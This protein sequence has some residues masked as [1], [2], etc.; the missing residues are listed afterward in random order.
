[1][2]NTLHGVSYLL[3]LSSTLYTPSSASPSQRLPQ[4]IDRA[5]FSRQVTEYPDCNTQQ[6]GRLE[7]G[8]VDAAQLAQNAGGIQR[9]S[10]A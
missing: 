7:K 8:F 1:M 10:N 2:L 9:T 4:T 6:R 3:A 5:L